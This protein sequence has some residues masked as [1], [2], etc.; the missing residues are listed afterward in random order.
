MQ[1][2]EKIREENESVKER[3]ELA[4]ERVETLFDESDS[5]WLKKKENY[6]YF[7]YFV[8]V[9]NFLKS[10][11]TAYELVESGEIKNYSIEALKQLNHGL[12]GWITGEEI[13]GLS[14]ENSFTNPAYAVKML[15]KKDGKLLSFLFTELTGLISYAFTQKLFDI[16]IGVELFLE[17]FGYYNDY[18]ENSYKEA[19]SAV[20]YYISDYSDVRMEWRTREI[21]DPS[22]SFA[23]QLI[24]ES[25]LSDLR[26][27]Y[28]FGEYIGENEIGIARY[29]N[30]LSEEEITKIASTYTEG[31]RLGFIQN[32]VDLSKKS[33]VNIRYNLGFERVVKKAMEQFEKMGLKA[34]IYGAAKSSIHKRRNLKIGYTSV[35]PVK[36]FDY[37]HRFDDGLYLD[38]GFVERKLATLHQAYEKYADLAKQYAGPAVIEIFGEKPFEPLAKEECVTLSEKQQKLTVYY[39]RESAKITNQYLKSDEISFTI[40]AFP[41]PEIGSQF[42]EIFKETVKVNTLDMNV[43]RK[44]HQSLIDCLDQGDYV[45][46]LG[47]GE[48]KTDIKVNL[49]DLKNPEK[50]TIF[51]N[52]LAD[53]NI[54]VGEVFTSPRL[55]GTNGVLHVTRVFLNELEYKNLSLTF[56]DG[57]V[58]EYSCSNF[59]DTEK[60]QKFVKENLLCQHDTLPIGEFAIGTNTTAYKMARTFDIQAKMP[61]LIAEKTGPHFA[62]GDTCYSMS[63]DHKV[64]NPDGKEIVAR[65]NECSVLRKTDIDKAYFNCHTDITIPYD[66]LKEISVVKK[67]GTSVAIIRDGKFV[68]EGTE[69]LNGALE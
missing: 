42:D 41:I 56:K 59:E 33:V 35:F 40:I 53:V 12:Y 11:K 21:L 1:Y 37:D 64:Y 5:S 44:I 15:G 55:T 38:K 63:E 18:D 16:T 26:Y 22:I 14:Y 24:E 19:K 65:E 17:I 47:S 30:T 39:A 31:Y 10:I 29:L 25:D 48:N 27:L 62:V 60:N 43:Y 8:H 9:Q 46:V 23:S 54:P 57:M 2:L 61:I 3:Y 69:W 58:T 32:K 52:C 50:E 7:L 28:L 4:M 51:E 20:Y 6:N 49:I 13:E 67:D 34:T 45:H 36:Q 68:L 66:E